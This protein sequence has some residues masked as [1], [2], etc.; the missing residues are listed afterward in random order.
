MAG[1]I[2]LPDV[3]VKRKASGTV[4]AV[5]DGIKLKDGT[6]HPFSVK[7]GDRVLFAQYAGNKISHP[8]LDVD[9]AEYLVMQEMDLYALI[10][11]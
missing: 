9:G 1:R 4:V 7:P 5:G 6:L 3:A 8:V 2:H 11:P 10:V